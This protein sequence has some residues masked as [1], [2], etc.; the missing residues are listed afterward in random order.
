MKILVVDDNLA[1]RRLLLSHLQDFGS[2]QGAANGLEAL[3]AFKICIESGERYRLICLDIVMP[4]M[5]GRT[6]LKNIRQLEAEYS[7]STEEKA[8][9]IMTTALDDRMDI[10]ESFNEGCEGYVIKPVDK[11]HLYRVLEQLGITPQE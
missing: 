3:E 6:L 7:I 8:K 11:T 2:C 4:E 10:I 1:S 9:I 5:D